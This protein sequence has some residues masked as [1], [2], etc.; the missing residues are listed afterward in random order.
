MPDLAAFLDPAA[1]TK[2]QTPEEIEAAA[3]RWHLTAAAHQSKR[4]KVK[5]G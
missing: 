4:R 3:Y 1:P 2:R 5:D